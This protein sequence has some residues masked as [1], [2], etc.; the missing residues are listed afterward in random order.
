MPKAAYSCD[1]RENT[2]T[3]CSVGLILGPLA[4]MMYLSWR[5]A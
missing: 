2:E 4:L 1:F 5:A 3:V